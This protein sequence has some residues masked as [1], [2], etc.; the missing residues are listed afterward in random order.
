MSKA[1]FLD[2]LSVKLSGLP[3]NEKLERLSFYSEMIDDRIEDGMQEADA[4][5][6]IGSADEIADQIITDIPLAR[7]VWEKVSSKKKRKTWQTVLLAVGAVVWIPLLIAV[8]AVILSLYIALWAV[9]ISLYAVFLALVAAGACSVPWAIVLL[10][11]GNPAGAAF[12]FGAG[13]FCAGLAI[14]M[15]FVCRAVTKG[16]WKLSKKIS[17]KIKSLFVRKGDRS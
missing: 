5:A 17:G 12:A 11:R 8:I 1:E 15:F 4:V 10:V 16:V 13:V 7:L 6:A 2:A 9:V 3:E 14:L